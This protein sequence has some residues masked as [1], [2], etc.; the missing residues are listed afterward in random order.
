MTDHP[1]QPPEGYLI[2][3]DG[4]L[5][6]YYAVRDNA[7]G[8]IVSGTFATREEAIAAAWEDARRRATPDQAQLFYAASRRAV[9]AD[10][11]FLDFVEDGLTRRELQRDIDRRPQL[12]GRYASWLDKLP[13]E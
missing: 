9:E 5:D 6:P 11:L 12:W 1:L 13:E 4:I 8:E 2:L 7:L 3:A 10:L